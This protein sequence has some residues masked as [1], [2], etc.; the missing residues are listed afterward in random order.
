R[1][2]FRSFLPLCYTFCFR[3]K[4]TLDKYSL[5]QGLYMNVSLRKVE[6]EAD[7]ALS[8]SG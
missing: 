7:L 1:P 2:S 3:Y 8:P 6:Q 4:I 5:Q